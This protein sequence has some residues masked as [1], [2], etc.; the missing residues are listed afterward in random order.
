[1]RLII[2]RHGETEENKAGIKQGHLPGTLSELGVR[3][4]EKLAERLKDEKIDLIISS[5]LA[6]AL[7]TAKIIAKFHPDVDLILNEKLR[8][9][10]FGKFQGKTKKEFG[11]PSHLPVSDFAGDDDIESDKDFF[12]RGGDL[13]REVIGRPEENILLIGHGGIIK[14]IIGN[15]LG[16]ENL[17]EIEGLKNTSVS[18]FEYGEMKLLNCVRH[19]DEDTDFR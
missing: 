13:I 18:I 6:R 2:T 19:L 14:S 8:E 11:I 5:D 4:A 7:D 17:K 10:Y 1:M 16:I 3:Q 15:L 12:S 9:R